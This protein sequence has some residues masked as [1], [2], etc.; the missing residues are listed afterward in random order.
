MIYIGP[1]CTVC[2]DISLSPVNTN[3]DTKTNYAVIKIK[4]TL[5]GDLL[6]YF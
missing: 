5:K 1:F 6:A 4:F 3:K 2:T